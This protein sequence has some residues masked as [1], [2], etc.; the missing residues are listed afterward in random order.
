MLRPLLESRLAC[1]FGLIVLV[2]AAGPA[3]AH[4][5]L[6]ESSIDGKTVPAET[7]VTITLRFN[8]EL[9]QSFFRTTLIGPGK[10]RRELETAPGKSRSEEIVKLPPLKP[11]KYAIRYTVLAADSH[12]TEAVL[13]FAVEAT[14]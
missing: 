8:A 12:L 1:I 5:V 11:G 3:L 6:I 9:E 4:A 7:A 14:N 13:R 10:E 2:L